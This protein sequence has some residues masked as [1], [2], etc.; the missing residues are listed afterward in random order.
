MLLTVIVLAVALCVA[1]AGWVVSDV[2][3]RHARREIQRLRRALE[4][5]DSLSGQRPVARTMRAVVGTALDTA[6]R[7]RDEGFSGVVKSSLEG[8]GRWTQEDQTE[9]A[10]LAGDDGRVAILFS[11][12]ENSTVLNDQLGDAEWVKVLASHNRLI[13]TAV[14]THDG[15]IIKSQGD[16]F[17]IVFASAA[18]AVRG[19]LAIRTTIEAGDRRLRKRPIQ[20]RVGVHVGT[21]IEKDGDLF[22]RDVALAARVAAEAVGG[23][24][25]ASDAVHAA[26]ADEEDL[27]LIEAQTVELKGLSG[28]HRLWAV[29]PAA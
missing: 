28:T 26:V 7:M 2:R 24:I 21:A 5:H 27:E 22:G 13:Q 17:M 25:L 6:V 16:G 3:R 18:D 14:A 10:R 9:I 1:T 12:I 20:V 8:L 11:D 4:R 15:H 19:A 29:A 23:E